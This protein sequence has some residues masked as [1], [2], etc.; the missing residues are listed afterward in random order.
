ML[1]V[2]VK[3]GYKS[4]I[5]ML[6]FRRVL[7]V[8][9]FSPKQHC[10]HKDSE[11]ESSLSRSVTTKLLRTRK[12]PINIAQKVRPLVSAH[13]KQEPLSNL[14]KPSKYTEAIA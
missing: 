8:H 7:E 4:G 12:S 11:E 9:N 1:V 3:N 2:R 6:K 13:K 10:D 14:Q 5:A